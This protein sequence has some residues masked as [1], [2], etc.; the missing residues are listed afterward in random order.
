[1]TLPVIDMVIRWVSVGL[2]IAVAALLVMLFQSYAAHEKS[3]AQHAT[4]VAEWERLS[5]EAKDRTREDEARHRET[6]DL[7][8][9]ELDDART[10][11]S[12]R[13]GEI[14][15]LQASN[16]RLSADVGSLRSR[17][18]AFAAGAGAADTVG[19]C[20]ARATA[21]GNLLAEGEGLVVEG[22]GL[23]RESEELARQAA[24]AHDGRA[25]EVISCVTGWP[26][27]RAETN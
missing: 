4:Q 15:D 5:G 13:D 17:N 27:N 24:V 16:A 1:M 14:R 22:V 20:Q 23:R 6:V 12:R 21:L 10:K 26:Q 7:A 3:K 18:A 8:R 2:A 25:A 19:A 11:I 9:G